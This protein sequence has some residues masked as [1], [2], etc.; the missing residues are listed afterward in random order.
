MSM[1]VRAIHLLYTF[2]VWTDKCRTANGVGD[3]GVIRFT[4]EGAEGRK[5]FVLPKGQVFVDEDF[6]FLTALRYVR[7]IS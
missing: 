5:E 4:A 2:T 1:F 7:N 6:R 3:S